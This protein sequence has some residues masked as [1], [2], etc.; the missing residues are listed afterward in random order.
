MYSK[1]IYTLLFLC[2]ILCSCR[3]RPKAINYGF[4]TCHFCT[5]TIVD[6]QHAAQLVTSKGKV[7]KFDAIECMINHLKEIDETSV[8]LI[9]VNDYDHP[10]KLIDAK[11][12]Y[13]LISTGIS[14]PMGANLTAFSTLE[15]STK[16]LKELGGEQYAWESLLTHF[17]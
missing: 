5:M 16:A 7:F 6:Q 9:L 17:N 13:Y 14:S 12:G 3:I 10:G 2:F 8:S 11:T 1:K 15:S 4:D